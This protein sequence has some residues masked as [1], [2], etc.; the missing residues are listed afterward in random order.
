MR[1]MPLSRAFTWLEPGPVVL[2]TTRDRAGRANVMTITW[3]MV[4]GFDARFALTTGAWNHSWT[5]LCETM[6]CVLAVPGADL[7]DQVVGVG[8]CSGTEVDKFARFGL[9]A[10]PAR[11]VAAPLIA[12][13][14]ANIECRVEEI[15]PRLDLVLL[16]GLAAWENPDRPDRRLLHA[17]GDGTFTADGAGFDRREAMR[18]RL[19]GGL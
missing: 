16:Q 19:P 10:R 9:T 12:E 11:H 6:E 14:L 7:L 4:R 18:N 17:V 5:A 13:A 2:V 3:T 1:E 8:T 15:V